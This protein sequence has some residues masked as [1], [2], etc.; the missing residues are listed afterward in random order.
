M[1]Q[2]TS[3]SRSISLSLIR[4]FSTTSS[5][6][7][8][9]PSKSPRFSLHQHLRSRS[10]LPTSRLKR[11]AMLFT[12]SFRDQ[13]IISRKLPRLESLKKRPLYLTSTSSLNVS[14]TFFSWTGQATWVCD[15][16]TH[17]ASLT[18]KWDCIDILTL[19]FGSINPWIS[20]LTFFFLFPFQSTSPHLL[21][22]RGFLRRPNSWSSSSGV[23]LY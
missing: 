7:M 6:L 22:E 1:Q 20:Q 4:V 11:G 15:K 14:W 8:S 10:R 23:E 12:P 5:L 21:S 13:S 2:L 16:S 17:W 19:L 9:S 3:Q 18:L